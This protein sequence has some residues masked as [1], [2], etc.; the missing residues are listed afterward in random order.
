VNGAVN[1]VPPLI[2]GLVLGAA[3]LHATWNAMLRSG[4]DRL[5][6]ISLMCLVAAAGSLPF[7]LILP[8]PAMASWPYAVLSAGLQIGYCLFL[9]RAYRDGQLGQVYPIARGSAPLLVALGAAAVAGEHLPLRAVCGLV[10]VS[11]GIM[12]LSLGRGRPDA[13]STLAALI[14]GVFIAGYMV[15]DGIGVRLSGRPV[16]Y[17]VWMT[18]IQGV[19][20]PL[21]YLAIRRRLPPLRADRETFKAMGGGVL[22]L[23][24]YG[25][26]VWA[27]A[28]TD[29][30]K[31]SGLRETSILFAAVL[32]AVFL[33]ERLTLTRGLCAVVI[34]GGAILLAG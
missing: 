14:T 4:A 16:S 25:V 5:W 13:R 30:A 19:P 7:L 23:I 21:V 10:A 20:M 15:T 12:G 11:A 31:V 33:K 17:V 3:L 8:P 32:G 26:V 22:G 1:G 28:S 34:C 29:M 18:F 6:S 2:L 27:M 9:I 24:G